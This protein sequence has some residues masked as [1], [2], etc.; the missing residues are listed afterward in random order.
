MQFNRKRYTMC[1]FDG[2]IILA[3]I[4]DFPEEGS[5]AKYDYLNRYASNCYKFACSILYE[6][7]E[8]KYIY[9]YNKGAQFGK[10]VYKLDIKETYSSEHIFSYLI[11]VTLEAGWELL[12]H[13]IDSVVFFDDMIIPPKLLGERKENVVLDIDGTPCNAKYNNGVVE[14]LKL[15]GRK[16]LEL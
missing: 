16:S 5:D 10:Y 15:S 1:A 8:E 11:T 3:I 12:S 13:K 6:K 4:I 9:D 2:K 7:V 14:L